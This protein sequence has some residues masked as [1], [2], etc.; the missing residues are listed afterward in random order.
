MRAPP[1]ADAF[2]GGGEVACGTPPT[3]ALAA[4]GAMPLCPKRLASLRSSPLSSCAE[5]VALASASSAAAV[6][7]R[8]SFSSPTRLALLA[9]LRDWLAR[10]A[11]AAESE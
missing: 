8:Q 11:E 2:S 1:R 6:R 4:A 3:A 9:R 5:G 7:L 10:L